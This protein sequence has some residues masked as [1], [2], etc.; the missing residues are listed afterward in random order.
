MSS[1]LVV[2][3]KPLNQTDEEEA[4]YISAAIFGVIKKIFMP[5]RGRRA[6]LFEKIAAEE[7]I[8]GY[9]AR[10]SV[11]ILTHPIPPV[12]VPFSS[13]ITIENSMKL[14]TYYHLRNAAFIINN[15]YEMFSSRPIMTQVAVLKE[16]DDLDLYISYILRGL[17]SGVKDSSVYLSS[18]IIASESAGIIDNTDIVKKGNIDMGSL[19]TSFMSFLSSASSSYSKLTD[20]MTGGYDRHTIQNL[21]LAEQ[22]V[23]EVADSWGMYI[24]NLIGLLIIMFIIY[25][26]YG[27]YQRRATGDLKRLTDSPETKI[28][29]E[30]GRRRSRKRSGKKRSGKKRSGRKRRTSKKR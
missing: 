7:N 29:L 21:V 6:D 20:S 28:V 1:D 16:L 19:I 12:I 11:S 23:I 18:F 13:Y 2:Y 8:V 5:R 4:S 22:Q 30:F 14:M 24:M 25:F 9:S 26:V 17:T 10:K 27:I 3:N 15:A